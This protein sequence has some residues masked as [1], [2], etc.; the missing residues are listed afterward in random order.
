MLAAAVAAIVNGL[1]DPR[2]E[3]RLEAVTTLARV[4]RNSPAAV[5]A[6]KTSLKDTDERV[7]RA[8]RQALDELEK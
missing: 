4:R 6:L 1:R 8:A 7:Q 2:P 3:I 5:A